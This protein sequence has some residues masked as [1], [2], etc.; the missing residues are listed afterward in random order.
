MTGV[1]LKL[2]PNIDMLLM[3]EKGIRGGII[4]AIPIQS[5]PTAIYYGDRFIFT[6]VLYYVYTTDFITS[7]MTKVTCLCGLDKMMAWKSKCT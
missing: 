1:Q 4:H 3:V 7:I 2:L 5:G 6:T